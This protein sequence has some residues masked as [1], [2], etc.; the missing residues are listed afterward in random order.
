[1][2]PRSTDV[3]SAL[4]YL[5][6]VKSHCDEEPGTY[7]AFL[8][9]MREFKDGRVDPRGVI[10]RICALFHQHPTLLHGFNNW[11]PDGWR[12]EHSRDLRGVEIITIVT[13]TERTTRPAASYA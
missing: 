12:I 8:E 3:D 2:D 4:S 5:D 7:G 11:L 1:M 10:Q 9:V 6:D 13:P